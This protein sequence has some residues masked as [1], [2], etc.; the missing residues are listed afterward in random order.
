MLSDHEAISTASR[1]AVDNARPLPLP[2]RA[3]VLLLTA[4]S[5]P[6]TL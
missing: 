6:L 5:S 2:P 4:D 3:C 1:R